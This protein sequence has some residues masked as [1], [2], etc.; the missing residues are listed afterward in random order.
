[1]KK[2]SIV[3]TA[4]AFLL[5]IQCSCL[6][7]DTHGEIAGEY[8]TFDNYSGEFEATIWT[9]NVYVPLFNE[10]LEVGTNM[11][12]CCN[13]FMQYRDVTLDFTPARQSYEF[14][15]QWHVTDQISI[16][17]SDQC[18]HDFAQY[19][20]EYSDVWGYSLKISYKF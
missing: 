20:N 4:I 10:K 2:I 14:Y 13:D 12:C 17:L 6:A 18:L 16:K 9:V 15:L 11:Q 19:N 7:F 8:K 1:M 3:L 5:I